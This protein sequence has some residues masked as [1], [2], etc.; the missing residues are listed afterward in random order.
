L[1]SSSRFLC[2]FCPFPGTSAQVSLGWPW[3]ASLDTHQHIC[4]GKQ[5]LETVRIFEYPLIDRL[6]VTQKNV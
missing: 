1:A 2:F 6:A 5:H 3:S 4:A